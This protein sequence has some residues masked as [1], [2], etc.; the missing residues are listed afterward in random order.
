MGLSELQSDLGIILDKERHD[1]EKGRLTHT[2]EK[3]KDGNVLKYPNA[4]TLIG[5]FLTIKNDEKLR[6]AFLSSLT[7]QVTDDDEFTFH[8]TI[9][10]P[11]FLGT[12][13]LCFYT[14]VNMGFVNEAIDSMKKRHNRSSR[15]I[16][17]LLLQLIPRNY[18]NKS[19]LKEIVTI[20]RTDP[21]VYPEKEDL[22]SMIIDSRYELLRKEITKV[23]VEI[24]Q[25]K[26]AVSEKISLLGFVTD[27]NEL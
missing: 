26:K 27:Y 25:D 7:R 6:S 8:P 15:G 18:F 3:S 1:L 23:N 4:E 22:C 14:L 5:L 16:Y 19:Q 17:N 13:P 11:V 9:G 2:L 20:L 24:N 21:F 10:E 12:S